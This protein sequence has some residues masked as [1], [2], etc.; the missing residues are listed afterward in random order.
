MKKKIFSILLSFVLVLN[1][2][3]P[4]LGEPV[5][6]NVNQ[7]YEAV[8]GNET[9]GFESEDL[10]TVSGNEDQE[11]VS[12]NETVVSENETAAPEENAEGITVVSENAKSSP[13]VSENT[14]DYETEEACSG[15]EILTADYMLKS[16]NVNEVSIYNRFS[17]LKAEDADITY[18]ADE[19]FFEA[20]SEEEALK[21]AES[22]GAQ[23]QSFEY[24]IGVIRFDI[25]GYNLSEALLRGIYNA[26]LNG[27]INE[28]SSVELTPNYINTLFEDTSSNI[29]TSDP[30]YGKQ[31]YHP[32]I[33]DEEAWK[34][35]NKGEGAVVA[36]I[37][38]GIDS[39]H[40]D[41]VNNIEGAYETLS[42]SDNP[43][44]EHSHGT[45]C[46]GIIAA[47]ENSVGGVGVA[48]KAKVISIRAANAEGQ[49]KA[50][51]TI[52]AIKLATKLK[53][54]VISMSYGR[55]TGEIP[56]EQNALD[57]AI[58]KGITLV[59]A[60]GNEGVDYKSFPAAYDEVI[61][62]ASYDKAGMLSYFS[63]YG[64]WV[65]IA[66]PGSEIYS[67]V[68]NS[69]FGY[70]NGT[71]MACPVISG[72]AALVYAANEN[73]RSE[74][75]RNSDTVAR[76]REAIENTANDHVYSYRSNSFKGGVEA[77]DAVN[78]VSDRKK[79]DEEDDKVNVTIPS[80][81]QI[82]TAADPITGEV[83]V[84]LT[85]SGSELYYTT[86]GTTPGLQSV[87]YNAPFVISEEGTYTVAAVA[88]N[89]EK[90]SNGYKTAASEI[91]KKKITV[92]IPEKADYPADRLYVLPDVKGEVYVVPGK[93]VKLTGT[94]SPNNAAK[95][96]LIFEKSSGSDS[97]TVNKSGVVKAAKNASS[98]DSAV[99]KLSIK[100]CPDAH[101]A[102]VT[103]KISS[104]SPVSGV[105]S[106]YGSAVQELWTVGM[107]DKMKTT[108]DAAKGLSPA[109]DSGVAYSFRSSK[110]KV[111]RVDNNGIVTAV[112]NGSAVITVTALD[113][114]NKSVK[115]KVKCKTPVTSISLN[116][117]TGSPGSCKIS[118]G[119]S[120]TLKPSFKGKGK[121]KPT[122]TKVSW[123][124]KSGNSGITVNSKGKVICAQNTSEKAKAVIVCTAM[125]GSGASAEYTVTAKKMTKYM[126]ILKHVKVLIKKN[127]IYGY[128]NSYASSAKADK[129]IKTGQEVDI[130]VIDGLMNGKKGPLCAAENT[131][132][133][134]DDTVSRMMES[135]EYIVS[136]GKSKNMLILE[137]DYRGSVK[138]ASFA[139][140][141]TY[142][143]T[144]KAVDG[145]GKK[146]TLKIK[147]K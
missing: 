72:V 77:G 84:T 6:G 18:D 75:G 61:A 135:D 98:G 41:L 127:N 23:L 14:A 17:S 16:L 3:G 89:R 132:K 92:K 131:Y 107:S 122:D 55:Y 78:Y 87:S 124:I 90:I 70:K 45:H 74:A 46:A 11:A 93:S 106:G 48:P 143:I 13:A 95:K 64:S 108:L 34:L 134:S 118:A 130:S 103:I 81:P 117:N 42:G 56:A 26:N 31:W 71:S 35:S 88:V 115:I 113:G 80:K 83:T 121:L 10:N 94:V 58:S 43:E 39:D 33:N 15:N 146:F 30:D 66:S 54:N 19:A 140:P 145:S 109:L 49:L 141:G 137:Q 97:I 119:K 99:I 101:S 102:E 104:K 65:D 76:V 59:A 133:T 85:G 51:D 100:D 2:S 60:A 12:E 47:E 50:S 111:A 110:T 27:K 136:A 112:G 1:I 147:V 126:G 123:S 105:T 82:S 7:N 114:S 73:F 120:I 29:Y 96:S 139:R 22:Y 25:T 32:V 125:D 44:D 91:E 57:E 129:V 62:V 28:I 69:K 79:E 144:Y 21:I 24:G 68:L 40:I 36:V 138:K 86:D 52:A 53:V 142:S 9:V 20:E 67:T 5:S 116:S 37:D 8:S 128:R 63:N 4:V 38:T